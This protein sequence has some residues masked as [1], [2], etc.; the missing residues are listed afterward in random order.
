MTRVPSSKPKRFRSLAGTM[1]VPRLPTLTASMDSSVCQ[2]IR[3]SEIQAAEPWLTLTKDGH[4]A[5]RWRRKASATAGRLF[6]GRRVV[7]F[8][9]DD[10][11]ALFIWTYAWNLCAPLGVRVASRSLRVARTS[12]LR[13]DLKVARTEGLGGW[14]VVRMASSLA[15][16]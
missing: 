4:P 6:R 5:P 3:L 11:S 9:G 15:S 13:L 10:H 12:S 14:P 8:V 7:G 2:Y 1:M 16:L